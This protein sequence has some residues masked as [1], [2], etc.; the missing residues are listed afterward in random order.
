MK[1][2]T[3][4]TT[5]NNPLPP[6]P[7]NLVQIQ[8]STA[9]TSSTH[10][11][12]Q[13]PA[14]R[15]FI[16][17]EALAEVKPILASS[18]VGENQYICG[19]KRLI[20]ETA[21]TDLNVLVTGETG[22]GKELVAREVHL[23]SKR[24]DAP[25]IAINCAAIPKETI[26]AELFGV[27]KGAFTDAAK[28][29]PGLFEAANGGTI[30]LDEIGDLDPTLRAKLKRALETGKI[31]RVG[32]KEEIN[33]STRV[34]AATNKDLIA[35][36]TQDKSLRA[37]YDLLSDFHFHLPPLRERKGDIPL[38]AE[39]LLNN[40]SG[41]IPL[42]EVK[43]LSE[44][45]ICKLTQYNWPGNIR[46]LENVIKR[47]VVFCKGN[48]ITEDDIAISSVE[49]AIK[50]LELLPDVASLN[51]PILISGEVGAG[52]EY[53]AN[54]I[55]ALSQR[56]KQPFVVIDC[57]ALSPA[58]AESQ[59]F[60]HV[61]GAFTGAASNHTG[62][63]ER[64]NNGT[65]L[66]D[67][68]EVLHPDIQTKLLR[69]IQEQEILPVGSNTHRKI[70]IRILAATNN[71]PEQM[72]KDGKLR[73]DL[74]HRLNVIPISIPPLRQRKHQIRDLANSTL[75]D[76]K[77]DK[78]ITGI[79]EA[80]IQKLMQYD[81]PGN[82]RQ[83]KKVIQRAIVLAENNCEILPE[84]IIFDS[85]SSSTELE[86]VSVP[87]DISTHPVLVKCKQEFLNC[88]N[89]RPLER[90]DLLFCALKYQIT[91]LILNTHNKPSE[92]SVERHTSI[93]RSTI[94]QIVQRKGYDSSG[95][96][97]SELFSEIYPE[98]IAQKG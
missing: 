81:W 7:P 78:N 19:I 47:A 23:N 21:K 63:L 89:T 73:E 20:L 67:Q 10:T 37:L 36:I 68:L 75:M 8:P 43:S 93:N 58:L 80:A 76:L 51:I 48:V 97:I 25:F 33:I 72:I 64:A 31:T 54:Q 61:K 15:L 22:T 9:G 4:I 98:T 42:K 71:D 82:I 38:I 39:H 62:F 91:E 28:T 41:L 13:N 65:A 60:G 84:H 86:K 49:T 50:T 1:T 53:L 35:E 14:I 16:I 32:G 29:K 55:H 17:P 85:L 18:I 66:L 96:L 94:R 56:E 44:D 59:L 12:S 45:A 24:K 70:D 40:F 79:T 83:L 30:F 57:A 26:D 34:I 6:I 3:V 46:E 5:V 95:V 87:E 2:S 52:K 27:E 77:G 92:L 69:A 88:L 11:G 90:D 74:F